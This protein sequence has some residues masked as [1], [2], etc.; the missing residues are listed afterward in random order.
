MNITFEPLLPGQSM[1][2]VVQAKSGDSGCLADV[3]DC[4]AAHRDQLSNKIHQAGVLLLRGFPVDSAEAFRDVCESICPNLR[5]Y[6][7][8]DSPRSG[9]T[10]KVYTSSD[11]SSD[12]EVLLHNELSYAGWSPDRVFFCCPRRPAVKP[13]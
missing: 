11:Y 6:T 12:L 8:G 7:G 3:A 10:D 5:D 13:K 4:I 1:P 2:I 9:V